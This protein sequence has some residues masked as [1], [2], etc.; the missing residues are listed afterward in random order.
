VRALL[1][2]KLEARLEKVTTLIEKSEDALLGAA[3]GEG[4][5]SF[6]IDTGEAD[7]KVIFK[8]EM[9]LQRFLDSLYSQQEMLCRRLGGNTFV[10]MK[11]RRKP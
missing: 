6:E 3:S 10:T 7:Q 5:S 11:V 2:Q 1:R 4:I 8:N 9:S